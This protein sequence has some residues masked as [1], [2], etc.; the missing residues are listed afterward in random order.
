MRHEQN[1]LPDSRNKEYENHTTDKRLW[2]EDHE[3]AETK[4]VEEPAAEDGPFV[5]AE[6][7]YEGA[8]HTGDGH[9]G[10]AESEVDC[11]AVDGRVGSYC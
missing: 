9:D 4:C 3:G 11:T 10:D 1:S 2:A 7:C 6:F 5:A 8:D